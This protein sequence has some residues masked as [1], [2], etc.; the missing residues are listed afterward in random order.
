MNDLRFAFRQ[1]LK[2]PGFTAVA[3]V[4]LALG[5]G[6]NAAVF[7]F[8][9]AVFFQNIQG[10]AQPM[11]VVLGNERI[12]YPAYQELNSEMS[13]ATL[14]ACAGASAVVVSDDGM[15]RYSVPAV[16]ENYF[17]ALG[18]RPLMG[19]FFEVRSSGT[20]AASPEIVLDFQFWQRRWNSDPA[21]LGRTL[22]L[23]GIAFTVVGIAPESFHGSGPERPPGWVPLGMLPMLEGK[24]AVWST[25]DARQFQL[26]GRLRTG[27]TLAQLQAQTAAVF[28]R[29]P[30]LAP[31]KPLNFSVGR[32]KWTGE[33]SME[34]H[35]EFLLV[36]TV[37]LVATGTILWIACSNVAN[38]LLARAVGRRR[39]I[40]IRLATG[41]S[42]WRVLRLLLL[43]SLVL[44]LVG[45]ALGLLL[46]RWTVQ[47]VFATFPEFS[48]LSV[49]LDGWVLTYTAAISVLSTILFGLV[50]GLQATRV[51]VTTGLRS[52][53]G[54]SGEDSRGSRLRMFLLIT[55]IAC[56]MALLVVTA[57]FVRSLLANRFGET[58]RQLDRLLVARLPEAPSALPTRDLQ[59]QLREQLG[60]IPGVARV[61]LLESD[62][63]S[64]ARF[65]LPNALG[66][67]TNGPV[68][69][70][71]RIDALY[72]QVAG[73]EQILGQNVDP[74][75]A[76]AVRSDA[77]INEATAHRFWPETQAVGQRFALDGTNAL[78]VIG[79]VRDRNEQAQIYR[80][81]SAD[82]GITLALIQTTIPADP[83]VAAVRRRL[84][85]IFTTS[86]FPLVA[87]L[88]D[89]QVGG[90]SQMTRVSALLG[91]IALLLSATGLYG[92]MSFTSS[93]R[94]RE[95]G[96]RLALGASR[97]QV[98]RSLVVRG[99]QITAIGCAVGLVLVLIAFQ[100]MNGLIFGKWTLD[101]AALS[102]V[103]VVF[104]MVTLAA[105][106]LPAR[107]AARVDPMVALRSE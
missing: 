100:L 65:R 19:R 106:W 63:G 53:G 41:A 75:L 42:R 25:A 86:S 45:G 33:E 87:T 15:W 89:A 71:Q 82:A 99:I 68:V 98:A 73:A 59:R 26:I 55:Q 57:T 107:R 83:F 12:S 46:S 104:A 48:R 78:T 93:Q 85:D 10:V 69:E 31:E 13:F 3:I 79:V 95:M 24:P 1:L 84:Q 28:A 38:L 39:E 17:S 92:S 51:D 56:S 91:G 102:A 62:K 80:P 43:E 5:I 21:A 50:P 90:L 60:T 4:S 9:N 72:F 88:R 34:K 8:I 61:T 22:L 103:A 23:N 97:G 6:L 81:L 29:Q 76:S 35:A 74:T 96:I 70:V 47:F 54:G 52:E 18:V 49:T 64:T 20:P 14:A 16:S 2:N 7:S 58:G 27:A 37:P 94:T 32:E 67:L 77:V 101:L 40:A 105:C 36:T 11:R 66:E 44:A 30:E